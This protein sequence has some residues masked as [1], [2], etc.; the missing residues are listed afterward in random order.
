MHRMPSGCG[1][2]GLDMFNFVFQHL[3]EI[4]VSRSNRQRFA[5]QGNRK[6]ML[7]HYGETRHMPALKLIEHGTPHFVEHYPIVA[8]SCLRRFWRG[9]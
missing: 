7:L 8:E 1:A 3:L 2:R 9:R 4:F 6:R 5:I